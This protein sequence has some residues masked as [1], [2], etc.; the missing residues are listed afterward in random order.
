MASFH[1][2][3]ATNKNLDEIFEILN[4]FEKEAPA[5]D[6][7]HINRPKMKQTLMM[8]LEKGKIILIKDLDK[9]KIVGITIFLFNEYLWSREQL[10]SVQVIYILKEYRS[11]KLFNQTMDIIKN[12]AKGRHIHLTISTRLMADKLLDRYGFEKLGGLW[13]YSNV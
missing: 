4:E 6:Y 3:E 7:P 5:L 11:F 1:F 12:Q 13:R 9:N 10:L 2:Y 8:F